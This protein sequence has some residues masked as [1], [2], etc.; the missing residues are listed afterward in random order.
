MS[1]KEFEGIVLEEAP[2]GTVP[3]C[4]ACNKSL[5]KLWIKKKGMGVL[6]QKQIIICPHCRVLLGYGALAG[7]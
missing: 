4:P 7:R 3:K 2:P 5:E 1:P 6:E